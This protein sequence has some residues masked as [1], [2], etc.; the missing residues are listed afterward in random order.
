MTIKVKT[1][2]DNEIKE[3]IY[4]DIWTFRDDEVSKYVMVKHNHECIYIKK[5]EVEQIEIK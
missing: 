1:K 3:C 5:D 2:K 4:E